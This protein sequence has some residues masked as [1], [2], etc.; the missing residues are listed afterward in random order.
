AGEDVNFVSLLPT[1]SPEVIPA[2]PGSYSLFFFLNQLTLNFKNT[3]LIV[4]EGYYCYCGSALGK[5]GL[6]R[7]ILR[8][9][10]QIKKVY[11]HIDYLTPHARFLYLCFCETIISLECV[12]AKAINKLPNVKAPFPGFGS[13]D[14]TNK[15]I[16]H[17]L[18]TPKMW[19]GEEIVKK[20]IRSINDHEK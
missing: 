14:C 20:L 5:G 2:T 18:Y 11:W 3:Q 7:R 4:N 19:N 8:H 16:S 6:Q 17:L 9:L 13:T 1:F 12:F 10:D 15:C